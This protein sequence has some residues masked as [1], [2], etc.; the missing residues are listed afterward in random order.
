MRHF[1]LVL[2]F[3]ATSAWATTDIFPE[4]DAKR[5]SNRDFD[6]RPEWIEES[7]SLPAYPRDADLIEF[8]VS[9]A[10]TNRFFVDGAT[11]AVGKDGVIRFT[12]VVKTAG[13]A[14][15]VS[16]EGIRCDTASVKRY[17]IGRANGTWS[18]ARIGDWQAIENKQVNRHFAALNRDLFCP[19]GNPIRNAEEGR[20]ALRRGLHPDASQRHI[21]E[22]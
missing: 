12:L 14:T 8:P 21:Y 20:D 7:A 4:P 11:L 22:R 5:F 10:T 6:T 13:G 1:P 9:A 18:W 15:N 16:Y 3:A 17:A 2:A 19:L